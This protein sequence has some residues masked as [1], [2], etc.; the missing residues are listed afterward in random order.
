[1]IYTYIKVSE[2]ISPAHF[3]VTGSTPPISN[4]G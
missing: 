4:I 2:C 3:S 1:M